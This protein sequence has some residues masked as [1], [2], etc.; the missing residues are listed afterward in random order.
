M[1]GVPT[2]VHGEKGK[3]KTVRWREATNVWFK[4]DDTYYRISEKEGDKVLKDETES[5]VF[6]DGEFAEE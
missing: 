2:Y 1:G 3:E 6:Y 5:M 4:K